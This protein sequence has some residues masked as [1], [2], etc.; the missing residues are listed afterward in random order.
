[1]S[2][3][4]SLRAVRSLASTTSQ[5]NLPAHTITDI[6]ERDPATKPRKKKHF[7]TRHCGIDHEPH[8]AVLFAHSLSP[9]LSRSFARSLRSIISTETESTRHSSIARFFL[10]HER[11]KYREYIKDDLQFGRI[12][13]RFSAI[14]SDNAGQQHR[15][16]IYPNTLRACARLTVPGGVAALP[17]VVE[18]RRR[19]PS[20]CHPS[21][22]MRTRA[23]ID[24]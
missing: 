19:R 23:S 12:D 4:T 3:V 13:A 16:A 17:S 5:S 15:D 24:V 8:T 20:D 1:M 10:S 2:A 18:D 22:P 9:S 14:A 11:L 6:I 21:R 7:L